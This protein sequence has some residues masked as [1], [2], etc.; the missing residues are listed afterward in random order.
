LGTGGWSLSKDG[1]TL[2]Q[3]VTTTNAQGQKST[4]IVVYDRQE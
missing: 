2:T 3:T 4:N 1:K